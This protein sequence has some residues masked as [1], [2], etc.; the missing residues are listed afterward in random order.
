MDSP[1]ENFTIFGK[2]EENLAQLKNA[3]KSTFAGVEL[4]LAR[5]ANFARLTPL[6]SN[7]SSKLS[8]RAVGVRIRDRRKAQGLRT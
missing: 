7:S 6:R 5:A 1:K 2:H 4:I 8:R 3:R